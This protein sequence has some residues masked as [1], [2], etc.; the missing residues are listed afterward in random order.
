LRYT[1]A[2]NELIV[3]AKLENTNHNRYNEDVLDAVMFISTRQQK[4]KG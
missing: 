2:A 3:I 1:C 4:K